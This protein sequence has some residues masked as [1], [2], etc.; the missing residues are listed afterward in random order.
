MFKFF[1]KFGIV[2]TI[3]CLIGV[4]LRV[5][6]VVSYKKENAQKQQEVAEVI[7]ENMISEVVDENIIAEDVT[8]SNIQKEEIAEKKIT[9][10]AEKVVSNDNKT[11]SKEQKSDSKETVSKKEETVETKKEEKK[12][13]VVETKKEETPITEKKEEIKQEETKQEQIVEEYKINNQMINKLKETIE[14][15]ESEDMKNY[16]YEIDVDSSIVELTNQ[17][18][19]TEYRV[20]NKL[21]LKYGIIRIYARDYYY[22]GNYM[23]TQCFII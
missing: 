16:G 17:F 3:A 18:T 19:Y 14:K 13:Q 6:E 12:E 21:K 10:E 7:N 15:N 2:L 11:T 8:D 1:V 5:I 20:K 4:S 22:N 23:T 9:K